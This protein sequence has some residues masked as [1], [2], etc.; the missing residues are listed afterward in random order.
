LRKGRLLLET[1]RIEQEGNKTSKNQADGQLSPGATLSNRYLIQGVIGVG[2]MGAVYRARDLHFPNVVKVVAVK[3]MVN[4]ARDPLVRET[5]VKNFEREANLLA[6]LSHPAIPRIHDYFTQNERS[7]LILE[8]IHGKDLE[9][10]LSESQDFFAP[11][12]VTG[13]GIEICDVL[14]YL[15]DHQPE[16]VIFRDI[17][18]SNIMVNQHNHIVLI[19]FG[20]A[21][22]FQSGEKGTMIGTEGYSPPE[23]YRG[24]ANVLADIYALGA[25]LHHLLSRRDPRLEPPFSFGERPLRVINPSVSI[26]LEAVINTALQY[27]PEDRFQ[28]AA[29][30][31]EA[32]L[33][34]ARETGALHERPASTA[35]VDLRSSSVKPK[36]SFAC[37]DEIRGTATAQGD[38]VYVG[39][40]DN[41]LYA[42]HAGT[43]EFVWK[44][45]TDGGIVSKPAYSN[46]NIYFGSED[47][48]VHAIS[49]RSGKIT[50]TYYTKGPVR[51]S[52]HIAEGHLFIG[53]DDGFLHAISA[54][55]GRSVWRNDA[56]APVRSTPLVFGE[57]IYFGT[58]AG[59]LVCLDYRGEVK[60]R[61][62]AKRA[63]T[64]SPVIAEGTVYSGSLD[65]TLYALDA[66]SGWVIWRF[67]MDKGSISTPFITDELIFTGAIDGNI[68]CID[69][70][71]AKEVWRFPTEHQVTGSALVTKDSVYCGSVDGNLYCLEYRTGRLRWKFQ[72]GG[73]ITAT[74]VVYEDT[75][76]IGSTDHKIYAFEA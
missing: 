61:F 43:G 31:K 27:N 68:Y 54:G 40:Y 57:A 76:Y 59:E 36:W 14:Q 38:L 49:A 28:S 22:R 64:S 35:R 16:P 70:H 6:T 53:S 60:W 10:I 75:V 29:E 44:Y 34:V 52:A 23:Q 32:L 74:P 48:R 67:R 47:K 65:G 72:T 17:K 56:F 69:I 33:T 11:D 13:W 73:P 39:S 7:Y 37:E 8:Y 2:G 19:D 45:P 9:T 62:R 18:P 30:M 50:W 1:Q 42:L 71:T 58:E 3:E 20:I 4:Q 63:I 25:T 15:H 12:Q 21:K 46:G 41:N 66:K 5:I 26:E 51:S 24:E 55:S